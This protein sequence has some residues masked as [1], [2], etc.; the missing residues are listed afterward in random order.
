MTK[1]DHIDYWINT[2][3]D[4]YE[5][6]ELLLKNRNYLHAMFIAHLSIEK[7]IKAHWVKDN[8]N[9][10][11][12][13]SHNLLT[14]A[15]QTKFDFTNDQLAFLTMFNDFQIQGRYPDYKFKVKK[16]LT[17]EYVDSIVPKISRLRLCLKEMNV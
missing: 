16:S 5:V 1:Q 6:F 10:I 13:K 12:P 15:K 9:N 3:N 4:D 7:L 17:K 8:E 2:S 14:L 11:P